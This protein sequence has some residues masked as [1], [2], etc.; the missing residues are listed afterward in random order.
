MCRAV[1]SK[2]VHFNKNDR[3]LGGAPP[4]FSFFKSDK[5]R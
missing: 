3:K 5:K 2:L 1:S 4:N